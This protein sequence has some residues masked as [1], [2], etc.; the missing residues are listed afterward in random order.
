[1]RCRH[2]QLL[3]HLTSSGRQFPIDVLRST[4]ECPTRR[5]RQSRGHRRGAE[6]TRTAFVL[7]AAISSLLWCPRAVAAQTDAG[8]PGRTEVA[9]GGRL[10]KGVSLGSSDATETRDAGGNFTLFSTKSRFDASTAVEVRIGVKVART[11]QIEG[12]ASLGRVLL[13][14]AIS[15][16]A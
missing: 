13:T 5:W 10:L 2:R 12:S 7:A 8:M 16:D 6:V 15:A 4:R 11:L 3:R 1:R 14:T 9:V